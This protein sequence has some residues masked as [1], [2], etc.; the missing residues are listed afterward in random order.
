MPII[1]E[2][3][4]LS[5]TPQEA[6]NKISRLDFVAS[7]NPNSGL[8]TTIVFQ[9]SR[10]IRYILEVENVGKW[11]SERL[12]IPEENMIVTQRRS[13]LSPFKYMIVLHIFKE[14]IQG[15]Q[16]TYIEEFEV[17]EE[18]IKKEEKIFSDITNKIK[19][20]LKKI[21]AYFNTNK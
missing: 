12:L 16:L 1:K 3:I 2:E 15:T 11:E 18:N 14:H 19:P 21:E 10:I 8:N 9:N 6:F 17:D 20:N 4:Y 13:P 7:I 5:C